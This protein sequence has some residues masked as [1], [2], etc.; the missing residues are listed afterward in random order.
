MDTVSLLQNSK[1]YLDDSFA[2]LMAQKPTS[3]CVESEIA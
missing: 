2:F 3:L 1:S